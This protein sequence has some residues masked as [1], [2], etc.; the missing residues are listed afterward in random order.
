MS[1]LE[2]IK[3]RVIRVTYISYKIV[4]VIC[5]FFPQSSGMEEHQA[6]DMY[7][8][9]GYIQVQVAHLFTTKHIWS[10]RKVLAQ[11]W[12]KRAMNKEKG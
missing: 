8:F 7:I 12:R 5:Y 3:E 2:A 10:L 9:K 11:Q 4:I 6:N 1:F